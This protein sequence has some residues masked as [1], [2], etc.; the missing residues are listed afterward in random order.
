MPLLFTPTID[1]APPALGHWRRA[2]LN[3]LR[4]SGR[5][6]RPGGRG[7][8]QRDGLDLRVGVLA[9][10]KA[11]NPQRPAGDARQQQGT[12]VTVP[13]AD[14][15]IDL[16]LIEFFDLRPFSCSFPSSLSTKKVS[17]NCLTTTHLL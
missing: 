9:W 12:V 6:L 16:R 1:A 17:R 15:H 14:Q 3:H 8:D 11:E 4:S 10:H 5:R 13:D 2:G 7:G